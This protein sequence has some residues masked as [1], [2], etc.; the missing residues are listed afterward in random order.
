VIDAPEHYRW[1]SFAANGYGARD[2]LV[3]PHDAY[4]ELATNAESRCVRYRS[5]VTESAA[6]EEVIAIRLYLQ[7]QRAMG[8]ARFQAEVERKLQRRAGLG[9]PGRPRKVSVL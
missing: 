2:P 4:S 7:R 8:S 3:T 5:F 9:R 6:E 1:S